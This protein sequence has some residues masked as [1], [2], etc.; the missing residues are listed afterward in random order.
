MIVRC[1][2]ERGDILRME[3]TSMIFWG[4]MTVFSS[5]AIKEPMIEVGVNRATKWDGARGERRRNHTSAH[6]WILIYIK[7]KLKTPKDTHWEASH[8]IGFSTDRFEQSL[9]WDDLRLEA[10][11]IT[12]WRL[13]SAGGELPVLPVIFVHGARWRVD[14][15]QR[16]TEKLLMWEG[17]EMGSSDDMRGCHSIVAHLRRLAQWAREDFATWMQA[18]MLPPTGDMTTNDES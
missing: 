13:P 5:V 18:A 12:A 11:V 4:M 16:T 3:L 8:A 6:V 14:F 1:R 15:A 17:F 7:M 10:L 9:G 2:R